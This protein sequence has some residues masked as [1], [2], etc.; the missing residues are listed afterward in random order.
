MKSLVQKNSQNNPFKARTLASL[1]IKFSAPAVA[2]MFVSALYNIITRVY[3]GQEFGAHGIAGI[4]LLFPMGFVF[5]AFGVLIGVG[6]NA[7]FSLRLGE[8]K[9]QEAH[10]IIGNAFVMLTL[11]S[12]SIMTICYIFLDPILHFLGADAVTLPYARPYMQIVLPGYALFHMGAG[13]NNF[14]RSCGHPKTAMA[15][16]F[17]GAFLNLTVA[18]ITIFVLHW[19]MRGAAAATLCGQ[20][21]SFIWIMLFFCNPRSDF[22]LRWRDMRLKW[23]L[24][25]ASMLIGAS[26]MFFQLAS[27]VL[28]FL[29]NHSLL[30]YGGNLAVSAMGIAISVN[31]IFLMPLLGLSQG[32]QPLIGYNFGA[33]K[34]STAFQTLKMSLRWGFMFGAVGTVIILCFAPAI[35]HIFNGKDQ[36]LISLASYSIRVMNI[37]MAF[38]AL[39]ILGT[40]FFQAINKPVRAAV[41]SLSRQVLFLI[42]LLLILPLFWG[43]D[44]VFYAAPAADVL[45][46][47]LTY[48]MLRS[49]FAKYKQNFF[50]G[51]KFK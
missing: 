22:R 5:M 31:A 50:W 28:N 20:I 4:T 1:L 8:K 44:G 51:K 42:P 34:F 23:G 12:V 17:I 26:Q 40:S 6:A 19:G 15:T 38:D 7:L 25:W 16:Q 46:C 27:A 30:H 49:Y 37:L 10:Q 18:P 21:V 45:T 3:V 32:A 47:L 2:G 36:D 43:L 24:I 9:E 41:L 39:Q 13:M 29:L 11:I 14:I 35:V 33:R 48:F